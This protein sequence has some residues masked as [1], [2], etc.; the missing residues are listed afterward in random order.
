[1]AD[2]NAWLEMHHLAESAVVE[3]TADFVF[4][5]YQGHATHG[6]Q[7]VPDV[8]GTPR[9]LRHWKLSV[10]YAN[11]DSKSK[12]R[13]NVVTESRIKRAETKLAQIEKT[14]EKNRSRRSNRR[15]TM[16]RDEHGFVNGID[17][18]KYVVIKRDD[19]ETIGDDV[20]KT[21]A[22]FLW[23]DLR[24]KTLPGALVIRLRIRSRPAR[25]TRAGAVETAMRVLDVV[26]PE[27]LDWL[28]PAL[29]DHV[30]AIAEYFR[31]A[32]EESRKMQLKIPD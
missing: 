13:S 4:G 11:S 27:P 20:Q 31:V 15:P 10:D 24:A 23:D 17:P 14:R 28:S 25:S 16:D 12:R 21:F 5:L 32:A 1:M 30:L 29:H 8:G 3:R 26:H 7:L 2:K 19:F 18:L 9:D 22:A 6:R